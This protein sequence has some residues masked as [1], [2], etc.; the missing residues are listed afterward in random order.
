[1]RNIR[2]IA[3]TLLT[4][5]WLG[6]AGQ[7]VDVGGDWRVRLSG[8]STWHA[9]TLPGTTD[10]AGLGVPN[11]LE[12]AMTKP[13][14]LRLTRK[15]R[16]VGPAEYTRT[17][18]IGKDMAGKPLEL[19]LERVMWRSRLS[20][21]GHAVGD[22]R[23][24]LSTPHRFY[25]PD[26]LSE[27]THRLTLAIDNGKMYEISDTEL[28]HAYTDDTQIKWNGV[29]GA[30][31]LR[32]VRPVDVASIQV[33]PDATSGE[34]EIVAEVNNHTGKSVR[35]NLEW[36]IIPSTY[37]VTA[38]GR[39]KAEL[40]PGFNE[41]RIAARVNGKPALWSEFSPSLYTAEVSAGQSVSDA[42]FGFRDIEGRDGQILVNGS[43][44]FLRGTLECCVFPLTGTPPLDEDGW[45]RVFDTAE[46]WG[47]N[48]LRFHSWCPPE[49]AFAVADRCGFYLQAELPLW[50]T[51]LKAG[52][53]GGVKDFIRSE[54]DRILKEYGNHPSLCLMT[55]GNELQS[56]FD[57]LNEMTAYMRARDD[58]RLY[59]ASSFT[60]EHGHG[61]HAE[62]FDQFM[63]SQWTD[64]G[65]VRGQGV[66]DNEPPSFDKDYR[67]SMGCV[68][69]P[70]VTHEIGQYAVYPDLTEIDKYTGVLDPLNFKAVEADLRAKGRLDR[71]GE[72]LKASGALAAILY[73]EEMERAMKTPG[74]AG[75]QL[76][77]L[78]DFPGQGTALVGLVNAFGESKGVA[79]PE[80]FRQFSS[81]IVPLARFGKATYTNDEPFEATIQ[82]ANYKAPAGSCIMR[83]SLRDSYGT[84]VAAKEEA[85]DSLPSG[86]GRPVPVKAE[87]GSV[88]SPAKLMLE[89][90]IE[91][92][93]AVNSWP[94][95]VYPSDQSEPSG[96]I[97]VTSSPTEALVALDEGRKVLLS[98]VPDSIRGIESKFVPVFWSPVH[99]PNQAGGM[100]ITC[101]A[102][103]PAL[104]CFPNDGHS[105]WQWWMPVKH[106]R[107]F[108][109]D[110]VAGAT[111]I[112]EVVDNFTSN[113]QLC[114]VAEGRCL[115][116]RLL[117]SGIDLMSDGALADPATMA[118]RR[119]LLRYMKSDGF[120][121]EDVVSPESIK[122]LINEL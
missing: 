29:L 121:P 33:Y 117:L 85:I 1:M 4:I 110:S 47:L 53:S 46:E 52:G 36:R 122:K 107:T 24:S 109:L 111:P 3:S 83:W 54:Y 58:R 64:D 89:V 49:A 9:I 81:P 61:G 37:G 96:D 76:L 18:T 31:K 25:L 113:R 103:H 14:L 90:R 16:F 74:I 8:D 70:L 78:S 38:T 80:W 40:A 100:G 73:K 99:F 91:G 66:F 21:D 55:V 105:D 114:L 95:W 102:R 116:G 72:Y 51:N 7:S 30:M 44:V 2:N 39:V 115:N 11:T 28:A 106:S 63:V 104:A 71:A 12:A 67:A 77:G 108:N 112:V 45:E 79:E 86:L 120:R 59:A 6:A 35:K 17:V 13:Q 20:V 98:P 88:T 32:V 68:N 65:W 23:E 41:V 19:T 93:D 15:N 60:F 48:H 26:G 101:D 75:I 50:S 22:M 92:S 10:Q 57:W 94:I 118:L 34:V 119:S 84:L 43:P 62:P 82:I 97:V 42:M 27:G 87:L 5:A 69:V 56:D